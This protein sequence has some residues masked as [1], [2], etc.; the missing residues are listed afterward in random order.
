MESYVV[1]FSGKIELSIVRHVLAQK[2]GQWAPDE[3]VGVLRQDAQMVDVQVVDLQDAYSEEELAKL[4]SILN[5]PP[6]Q[7]IAV[8][9]APNEESERVAKQLC[10]EL[11]KRFGGYF[12]DNLTPLL[13][14]R[15]EDR[16]L[17][18]RAI[19]DYDSRPR[20]PMITSAELREA[21]EI[22]LRHLE[23]AGQS[24]FIL[25]DDYYWTIP[26]A[27]RYEPDSL[28]PEPTYG[29]LTHD[30]ER[31]EAIRTGDLEPVGLGL[32]WLGEVLKNI[33]DR[34]TR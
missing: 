34:S 17:R 28:A 33:G 26:A 10:S 7:G 6:V 15:D 27:S 13:G 21:L 18:T 16:R 9:Y 5:A 11:L 24:E 1:V 30:H 8:A 19:K 29:Q 22:L 12:D 4:G 23:E 14:T 20:E 32:V 31:L 3:A 25:S 2:G